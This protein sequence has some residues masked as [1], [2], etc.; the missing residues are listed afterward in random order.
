[1]SKCFFINKDLGVFWY[2]LFLTENVVAVEL[3]LTIAMAIDIAI[4]AHPGVEKW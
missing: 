3:L 1:M 4:L 2:L